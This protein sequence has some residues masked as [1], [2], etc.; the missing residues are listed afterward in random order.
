MGLS[1]PYLKTSRAKIHLEN[2]REHVATFRHE[3]CEF[4]RE[5]DLVNQLHIL[6]MKVKDIPDT[7][8]LIAGDVLYSLRAS[9]D[10]LVWA[11]AKIKATPDYPTGTQFPILEERNVPRF[12]RQTNGIPTDAAT[13]IESLQPYNSPSAVIHEHL[14]WRLNKLC[15]IDKHI[16]I[17]VHGSTGMI[18]WDTFV[19]FGSGDFKLIEFDD[20]AEMRVP[21]AR[22]GEMALNPRVPEFKVLFGD[23]YWKI[24][25]DFA[26]LEAIYEFV[27]NNVIPRFARFFK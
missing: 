11:L 8:P 14:L 15:N 19:P 17:P 4:S 26:G 6:R 1:D 18:V 2:L 16:R 27:T 3:P 23:L 5:D 24:Q 20:N 22:K 25:C 7:L 13:I 9:L 21:L 12:R 10:Q